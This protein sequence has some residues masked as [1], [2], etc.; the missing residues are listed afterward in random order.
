[1]TKKLSF[2]ITLDVKCREKHS[3]AEVEQFIYDKLK[4]FFKEG[5]VEAK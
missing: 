3:I 4:P 2:K 5:R 1:M